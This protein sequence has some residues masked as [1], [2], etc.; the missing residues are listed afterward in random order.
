MNDSKPVRHILQE[1]TEFQVEI[2]RALRSALEGPMKLMGNPRNL[3]ACINNNIGTHYVLAENVKW[4][5]KQY[6]ENVYKKYG[7]DAEIGNIDIEVTNISGYIDTW[8]IVAQINF[9]KNFDKSKNPRS[10]Y[11]KVISMQVGFYML[12][13]RSKKTRDINYKLHKKHCK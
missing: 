10:V 5:I 4:L 3:E 11:S 12:Q 13:P 2:L 1:G 8:E 7:Y 9:I 6:I